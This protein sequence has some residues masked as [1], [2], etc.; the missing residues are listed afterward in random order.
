MQ[1]GIGLISELGVFLVTF[2]WEADIIELDLVSSGTGHIFRQGQI[3]ILDLATR[4]ISP[5][6]LAIF[7]PRLVVAARLHRQRTVVLGDV[8]IAEQ[9][10][11]G[12]G[13]QVKRMQEANKFRKIAYG[14][15][16]LNGGQR[17]LKG[18]V[19]ATV[20][21]LDVEDY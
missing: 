13:V 11:P 12:D 20:A 6:Q 10:D 7:A 15:V 2:G 16:L 14:M 17:V 21:V 18:N 5:D 19:D 1:L 8:V 4:G 9:C 3:V